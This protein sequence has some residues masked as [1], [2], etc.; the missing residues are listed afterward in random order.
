MNGGFLFAVAG[1]SARHPPV[2]METPVFDVALENVPVAA[3]AKAPST[4]T[5]SPARPEPAQGAPSSSPPTPSPV[6]VNKP[7]PATETPSTQTSPPRT[8]GAATG[9]SSPDQSRETPEASA[10]HT[11]KS[12]A[13]AS[14]P[15]APQAVAVGRPAGSY[16]AQ[17]R[18]HIESFKV[19]PRQARRRRI[20]GEVA[21]AFTMDRQGR[22]LSSRIQQ[23]SGSAELDQAALDMLEAAQPLPRPPADVRGDRLAMSYATTFSLD[24]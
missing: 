2:V 19:Y 8:P 11:T 16:A 14:T 4:A 24:D 21:V 9:H 20:E 23:S 10:A 13:Q 22:V 12:T 3:Q 18:R 15:A 7:A 5:P 1:L 17:L 6:A